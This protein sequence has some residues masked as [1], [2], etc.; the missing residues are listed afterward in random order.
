MDSA[1]RYDVDEP[2]VVAPQRR[3]RAGRQRQPRCTIA[4]SRPAGSSRAVRRRGSARRSPAPAPS[5]SPGLVGSGSRPA[6]VRR[7]R[8]AGLG[9]PPVVDDRD[10]EQ[11]ARPSGRCPGR[12]ARRPGTASAARQVVLRPA[13]SP[14]G[15]SFLIARIAVGAVNSACHA[16]LGDDPPE[17]AG[18]R[19]ADRLA[20]VQHRGR[21]DQQ[22]RVDDVGVAD[23]PADVARRSRTRRPGPD[24]VD[25]RHRPA[26]RDRVAAVVADDALRLPGGARG[27]E[28]VERVGRGDRH[29]VAPARRRRRQLG[30]VEVAGPAERRPRPAARCR[31]TQC[32]GWCAAARSAASSSGLYSTT[33]AASMPQDAGDDHLRPGV[34]DPGGELGRPRSRRTPPSAPR[35]AGRRPASRRPPRGPS[36]CR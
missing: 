11:L 28:D 8:P 30:P 10:A 2:L 1:D 12:A 19:G 29:A 27:V 9:L 22:R 26:Q 18:V 34:V 3:Q 33:R 20:L 6:R 15:S 14:S 21:A 5:A 16:V 17:R 32:S 23:D 24:V 13:S 31:I 4:P 36:A 25:V 35:R 7:D